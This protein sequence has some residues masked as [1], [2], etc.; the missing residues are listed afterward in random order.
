[1]LDNLHKGGIDALPLPQT[2]ALLEEHEP[3]EGEEWSS[4]DEVR[5][6]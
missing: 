6:R 3:Y 4:S 5:P 2:W 1:M